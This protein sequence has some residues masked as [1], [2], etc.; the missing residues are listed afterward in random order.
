MGSEPAISPTTP[1]ASRHFQRGDYTGFL[2]NLLWVISQ[3]IQTP[4]RGIFRFEYTLEAAQHNIIR[5][6]GNDLQ[7]VIST[8]PGA[9]IS[10]GSEIRPI[11]HLDQ[12]L[13][14]HPNYDHLQ[15]NITRGVHYPIQDL[16]EQTR[17]DELQKQLTKGNHKSALIPEGRKHVDKL[18][19]EDVKLGY[20]IPITTDCAAKLKHAEIYPV[21]L[22][23]QTTIDARGAS[24]PKKRVTHDLSN[25]RTEGKSIN[26]RVIEPLVPKVT[27]HP[28]PHLPRDSP[29]PLPKPILSHPTDRS[30]H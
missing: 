24:I 10:F 22:Q 30:R 21:G 7:N 2:R 18:M 29:L 14:H 13:Q 26:Q 11:E 1:T 17:Q 23:H 6:H 12:L 15:R 20:G 16:D 3:H 27:L 4:S 19:H 28:P 25:N 8:N 9:I 5:N